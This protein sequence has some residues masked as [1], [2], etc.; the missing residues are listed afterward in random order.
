MK[1]LIVNGYGA[2]LGYRKG[3]VVIKNKNGE[4]KHPLGNLDQIVL[5]TGGAAISAKLLRACAKNNVDVLILSSKG[6]P[7]SRLL[8]LRRSHV[9]LRL[10]QVKACGDERGLKIA[11]AIVYGKLRSQSNMLKSLAKNRTDKLKL[12]LVELSLRVNELAT[13]SLGVNSP[14]DHARGQLLRI[15]AEA[16]KIYWHGVARVLPRELNFTSRKK[17][18]EI[19][20]DPVNICLNYAYGILASEVL[21]MIELS[22]LDPWFGFLHEN[23]NR[24]PALVYDLMEL[25]RVAVV[26]RVIVTMSLRNPKKLSS[27]IDSGL[28]IIQRDFRAELLK[29]IFDRLSCETTFDGR[30]R[31]LYSHILAQARDLAKYL[32]EQKSEFKPFVMGW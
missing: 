19:P 16:A 10:E 14:L 9:K 4:E 18:F 2:F 26:D 29:Q 12:E 21:Q 13:K 7:V 5:A 27:G 1:R 15:E 20:E 3:M 24:R 32:L 17:R 22:G 25:F 11:R 23:S 6:R 8:N 28:K 31:P 30:R